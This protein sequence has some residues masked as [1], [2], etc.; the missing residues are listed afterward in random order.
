MAVVS[1]TAVNTGIQVALWDPPFH[2]SGCTHTLSCLPAH[3]A[4]VPGCPRPHQQVISCLV[5]SSAPRGVSWYLV[6]TSADVL[7][8]GV[9]CAGEARGLER[10]GQLAQVWGARASP[11][12]LHGRHGSPS[13][14]ST[15]AVCDAHFFGGMRSEGLCGGSPQLGDPGTG[16]RRSRASASLPLG[17]RGCL[18][19]ADG[20]WEA[21]GLCTPGLAALAPAGS[22][23]A[24]GG[25]VPSFSDQRLWLAASRQCR[26][27]KV[28]LKTGETCVCL[29]LLQPG[30]QTHSSR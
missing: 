19:L 5:D 4:Q 15:W 27:N 26:D 11:G 9:P 3:S 18:F 22:A 16:I 25:E 28:P 7:L 29:T 8:K 23:G 20:A 2:P 10:M 24:A 30:L 1:S 13:D 17:P 21:S 12:L 6:Q 14:P